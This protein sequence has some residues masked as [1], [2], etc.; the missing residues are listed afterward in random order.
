MGCRQLFQGLNFSLDKQKVIGEA[1]KDNLYIIPLLLAPDNMV[2]SVLALLRSCQEY[3]YL[4]NLPN[5]LELIQVL[6]EY[7]RAGLSTWLPLQTGDASSEI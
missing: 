3:Y 2:Q 1:I 5:N 4:N 7:A 6:I